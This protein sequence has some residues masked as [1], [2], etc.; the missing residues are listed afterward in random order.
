M[1][2]HFYR[3]TCCKMWYTLC[4]S[5]LSESCQFLLQI[6]ALF[7]Y[8]LASS[9]FIA[10]SQDL[11]I[12]WV[13]QHHHW[14][15]YGSRTYSVDCWPSV[16]FKCHFHISLFSVKLI[17]LFITEFRAEVFY[18]HWMSKQDTKRSSVEY[19]N[20]SVDN[21]GENWVSCL[22]VCSVC[23]A[24][25]NMQFWYDWRLLWQTI[26]VSFSIFS[27]EWVLRF[28]PVNMDWL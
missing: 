1:K 8:S 17:K 4:S 20:N 18:G 15:I 5:V 11:V 27:F 13:V 2:F 10:K 9:W 22:S 16:A 3:P 14:L 7:I 25:K 28:V 19:I 24:W 12:L 6:D 23:V 26:L 21:V